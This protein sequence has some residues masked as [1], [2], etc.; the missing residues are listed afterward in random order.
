SDQGRAFLRA[1][2]ADAALM[3]DQMRRAWLDFLAAECAARPVV[4]VVEDLHW[5][6]LPSVRFLDAS[7]RALSDRP[8][9]VLALGRPELLDQF[10][11]LWSDRRVQELRLPEL[12]QRAATD[13]VTEVLGER[14]DTDTAEAIV[15]RAAGNAY[16]LE[17]LIRAVA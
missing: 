7:L 11:D 6:D 8:L 2:R 4:I 15:Q 1:A 17:E 13:L 3:G 10:P 12:T 14:A 9:L 5:G 16:Y